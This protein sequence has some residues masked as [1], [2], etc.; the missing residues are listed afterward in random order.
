MKVTFKSMKPLGMNLKRYKN[1]LTHSVQVGIG[2]FGC[3]IC[4]LFLYLVLFIGE[5]N[6]SIYQE[7]IAWIVP[8]LLYIL[9]AIWLFLPFPIFC[10][11]LR[12]W[13]MDCLVNMYSS[14]SLTHTQYL[15]TISFFILQRCL[16]L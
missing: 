15:F 1:L 7:E 11:S 6:V 14:F 2:L 8:F 16:D 3:W 5:K 12:F 9:C 4:S 10:S 13:F